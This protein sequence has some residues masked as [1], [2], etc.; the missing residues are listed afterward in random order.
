MDSLEFIHGPQTS[1]LDS[2]MIEKVIQTP[3]AIVDFL[4]IF[5][6]S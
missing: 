3:L 4:E 5:V 1:I 6:L 2:L